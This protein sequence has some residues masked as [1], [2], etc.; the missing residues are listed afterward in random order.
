MRQIL[1]LELSGQD[2]KWVIT[3][4]NEELINMILP[5]LSETINALS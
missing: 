4:T 1:K 5:G 3:T 2:G